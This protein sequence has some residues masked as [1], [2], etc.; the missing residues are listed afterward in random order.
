M[1]RRVG[2]DAEFLQKILPDY[3]P[4]CKRLTPAPGY[5]ESLV[6]NK[7]AFITDPIIRVDESGIWTKS[8]THQPVDA[9]ILATGFDHGF[10]T[11]FP[12]IGLGGVD[13]KEKWSA[14]G[15]IGFPESYLGI[16]AP[17]IPN[18]FTILQVRFSHSTLGSFISFANTC[19]RRK[20][21]LAAEASHYKSS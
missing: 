2:G 9:I 11:K 8:G 1:L 16:M 5:L 21:M 17:E 18:Y 12:V 19:H 20:A 10:T 14:E 3:A 7:L 6:D 4:G 13:L 15:E